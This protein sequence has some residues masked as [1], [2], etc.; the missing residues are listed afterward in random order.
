[1]RKILISLTIIGVV[2]AI[3]IGATRAYFSDTETSTGNTFS[4]GSLDLKIN[5]SSY[6]YSNGVITQSPQTSWYEARDLTNELFFNF[7]DLKPGDG[8]EDTISIHL[9]GNDAWLCMKFEITQADDVSCSEPESEVD[10]TCGQGKAGELQNDLEFVFW[11][12]DGD[13]V[14]ET[15]EVGS[16]FL[17]PASLANIAGSYIPLADSQES[18]FEN[19][20]LVGSEGQLL[21][22]RTYSLGK[23]WCFGKLRAD[24][25]TAASVGNG[26]PVQ[27]GTMG[28]KCD[29]SS[30][31][32]ASQS[33][34]VKGK[35]SFV[36]VQFRNNLNF[37]CSDL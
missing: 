8:G 34:Q 11:V 19:Y 21:P 15:N 22:D 32:N 5:N 24:G 20:D 14:L 4:A 37:R 36:A 27:R 30:L 28:V 2:S 31:G 17:G 3:V 33:D 10:E 12:D 26:N 16:I 35:L 29:G 1:M 25:T 13:N 23:A 9:T 6:L 7:Y 18:V